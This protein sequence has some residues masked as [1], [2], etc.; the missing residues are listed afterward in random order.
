[1]AAPD[2]PGVPIASDGV[3]TG[4][5]VA[6]DVRGA[7]A[8]MR[9]GGAAID[10]LATYLLL[11]ASFWGVSS[12]ASVGIDQA[13]GQAIGTALLVLWFVIV[14][15]AVETATGGRSLGKLA[16]GVRVVRD[17]GGG[18]ALRHAFV[19]ALVGVFEIYLTFGG[20]AFLVG[21]LNPQGKRLGDILAGTHAQVERVPAP[22]DARIELPASLAGWAATADVGRMPTPLARRIVGFFEHA[23]HL[24]PARR[25]VLAT[26]LANEVAPYVSP[27][28][29]VPPAVLLAGVIAVRREREST[30]LGL[31]AERIEAL[32]PALQGLPHGFPDR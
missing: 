17:D 25:T 24:D 6:L 10:M 8:I 29:A 32:E 16:L 13:A 9:A 12:L 31:A 1:M 30:A 21:L 19:R 26:A 7:S 15:T 27:V 4:E 20:L 28:P 5:A 23:P 3:L 2:V 14:P 11:L 22:I 18:I